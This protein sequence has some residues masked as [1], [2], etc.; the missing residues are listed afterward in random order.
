MLQLEEIRSQLPALLEQ[1]EAG[2]IPA[3]Y[4]P[5]DI[6]AIK[7]LLSDHRLSLGMYENAIN[8][9]RDL[10][11]LSVSQSVERIADIE[12]RLEK[13]RD[14]ERARKEREREEMEKR[15]SRSKI[16]GRSRA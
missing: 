1:I 14:Q 15:R 3:E 4:D 2:Y 5:E 7:R 9:M 10:E 8:T 13:G 6:D 12:Q 16:P 11:V